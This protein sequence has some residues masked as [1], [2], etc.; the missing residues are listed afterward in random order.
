MCT[1]LLHKY[2]TPQR[3]VLRP[4]THP[5]IINVES[6]NIAAIEFIVHMVNILRDHI[7]VA[8][9]DLQRACKEAPMYGAIMAISHMIP[10][11]AFATFTT[12]ET[13]RW[14]ETLLQIMELIQQVL[15]IAMK[16]VADLAPEGYSTGSYDCSEN[17]QYQGPSGQSVTTCCWQSIREISIFLGTLVS[18]LPIPTT[19]IEESMLDLTMI[20]QI[21]DIFLYILLSTRHVG[22]IEKS[23]LHFQTLCQ[24]L[25]Q[26]KIPKIFDLPSVWLDVLIRGI[27][28]TEQITRRSAGL[29][30]GVR[31]ILRAEVLQVRPFKLALIPKVM[32]SLIDIASSSSSSFQSQV[33]MCVCV[34][35]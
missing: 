15:Q 7:G 23:Y 35:L 29:P 26:S 24:R 18:V 16:V 5:S 11:V 12:E 21:G 34:T 19:T 1:L 20:K 13:H 3:A 22:A 6:P 25:L 33:S 30:F 28:S 31:A 27:Q 2:V 10:S 17:I 9:H 14:K 8:Q 4:D 32:R